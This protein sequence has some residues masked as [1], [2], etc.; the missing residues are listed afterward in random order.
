MPN[1]KNLLFFVFLLCVTQTINSQSLF[2]NNKFT[3]IPTFDGTAVLLKE[4]PLKN[5]NLDYNF[6]ALKKW[7]K[8]NFGSD[9][10]VSSIKIKS[11]DRIIYCQS[12]IELLLPQNKIGVKEKVIMTYMLDASIINNKCILEI[13]DIYYNI[14]KQQSLGIIKTNFSAEEMASDNAM[15]INDNLNELRYNIRI[16]TLYFFNNLADNLVLNI[17]L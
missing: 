9:P 4:I 7:G 6:A 13:K 8:V 12:K 3:S 1:K 16:S 2:Q 11:K 5:N 14:D 17:N 15:R 10:L